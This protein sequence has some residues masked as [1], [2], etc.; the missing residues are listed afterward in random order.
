M[1]LPNLS[2]VPRARR[3][4]RAHW[5]KGL[6]GLL[7][8]S[9]VLGAVLVFIGAGIF[10]IERATATWF[11]RGGEYDKLTS[12]RA[13]FDLRYFEDQLGPPFAS[14]TSNGYR[15]N[16]FRGRDYWVQTISRSGTV[17]L[18]AVTSCDKSFHP[19]FTVAGTDIEVEL[20]RDHFADLLPGTEIAFD[21]SIGASAPSLFY[22]AIYGGADGFY[23]TTLWGLSSL[24]GL[25]PEDLDV[26]ELGRINSGYTSRLGSRWMEFRRHAVINTFAESAP[27]VDGAQPSNFGIGIGNSYRRGGS[28]VELYQF[29]SFY[30]GPDRVMLQGENR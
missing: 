18:Y 9:A 23:K 14:R 5:R 10:V 1:K 2:G 30:I 26:P 7:E 28:A 19:T 13:G 20:N 16:G 24:C 25:P 22:E 17:Q 21:Y 11:W 12:L 3:W 15:E 27:A 8:G 29:G 4:I 6:R